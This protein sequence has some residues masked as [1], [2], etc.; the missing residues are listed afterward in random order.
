MKQ[1][2]NRNWV[3]GMVLILVIAIMVPAALFA[4]GAQ[5][6]G[7]VEKTGTIL[8]LSNLSSGKQYEAT[9]NYGK[10]ICDELG[11]DF[12]VIYGDPY[13]DAAGNLSVVKNGMTPDVVGLIA[14]QD[15]G[16]ASIME[17]FPDLY[18]AGYNTDMRSVYSGGPNASVLENDHFLGTMLDG[19]ANGAD[20]GK[21]YAEVV[22]EKGYKKVSV[23]QFPAFAYPSQT[24]AAI[25]F[26][27]QIE[28]YNSTASAA[29]KITIVG[30]PV[31]LEF[32]PLP[33]SY[34]LEEDHADLDCIV[35][36]CAGILFVYPT[37]V[38][39]IANGI[40]SPDT[41]LITG[42]FEVDDSI[43]EDIGEDGIMTW[44]CIAPFE[45]SAFAFVL[46]DNAI[47]GNQYPDW[48][49]DQVESYAYIIDSEED[50]NN[51]MTKSMALG[52][53]NKAQLSVEEVLNLCVRFNPDATY[54]DLVATMHSDQLSVDA[55]KD[56]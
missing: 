2:I 52:D 7:G 42:G 12:K 19:F 48:K 8:W 1:T 16:L 29:D 51:V 28:V 54:A 21:Q 56:R 55:L 47:T 34:F 35:G 26:Y 5:E 39:A 45:D 3:L 27:K 37:Q 30:D 14:S 33:E 9:K 4:N 15:G 36:L 49:N 53:V 40:C 46:L 18:V 43:V 23:I 31:V 6:E 22:I 25:E 17:E 41:K 32:Q 50:I 13:N 11:Y 44:I 10:A 38:T 24:E 20:T